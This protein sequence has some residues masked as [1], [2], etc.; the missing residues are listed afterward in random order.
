MFY[1]TN[2]ENVKIYKY[3]NSYIVMENIKGFWYSRLPLKKGNDKYTFSADPE[4]VA[5]KALAYPTL[6]K[7]NES[8]KNWKAVKIEDPIRYTTEL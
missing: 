4:A 2:K 1:D 3:L 6:E 7:A 5:M 8:A